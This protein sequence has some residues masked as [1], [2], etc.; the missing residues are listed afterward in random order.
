MPRPVT[1]LSEHY[2]ACVCSHSDTAV[3]VI[4]QSGCATCSSP[5]DQST[6]PTQGRRWYVEVTLGVDALSA[7]TL[8]GGAA[9]NGSMNRLSA[10]SRT[11]KFKAVRLRDTTIRAARTGLV[12]RGARR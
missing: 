2:C 7:L 8:F 3:Q 5:V 12:F 9:S 1:A 6:P 11:L 10:H 4:A